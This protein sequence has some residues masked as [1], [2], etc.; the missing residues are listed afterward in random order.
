VV[1]FRCLSGKLTPF[2]TLL[3]FGLLRTSVLGQTADRT[4]WEY[5]GGSI[6]RS[7]TWVERTGKNRHTFIETARN[8]VYVE[9]FDPSRDYVTRLYAD[10][11]LIRGGNGTARKI[12]KFARIYGGSWQDSDTRRAWDY[13]RGAFRAPKSSAEPAAWIEKNADGL[14]L[15]SEVS[16]TGDFVELRDRSR[17]YT[18]RLYGDQLQ[19]RGGNST[20]PARF[21]EFT[22]IYTGRWAPDAKPG[23]L[24]VIV[25][26]QDAPEI[27]EWAGRAKEL[28]EIWHPII[29]ER[30][31]P[32]GRPPA[33]TITII[34]KGPS[35][36]GIAY[37]KAPESTITISADWVK[38][39]PDDVGM[40]IHELTHVVQNYP[41][42]KAS[43]SFWIVEGIADYVRYYEFEPER[44]TPI[45]W[46][47]TYRDGYGIASAF[48]DWIQRTRAPHIIEKLNARLAIGEYTDELFADYAGAPVERL[49]EEFLAAERPKQR[50]GQPN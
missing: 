40:V 26:V 5:D 31:D 13:G 50:A 38:K 14:H 28:C 30:L 4:R 25:D 36:K 2:A 48:L 10:K 41:K 39:H 18:I 32:S 17:D 45:D 42:S 43:N 15:F 37:T 33:R 29:F 6:K 22:R 11:A 34:F 46:K 27:A 16:R 1:T 12:P 49:W 44:R 3:A 20:V 35:M 47:K 9:L 19:I 7:L 24:A 8:P 23:R 21:A